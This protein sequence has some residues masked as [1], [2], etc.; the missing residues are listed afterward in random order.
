V[1]PRADWYVLDVRRQAPYAGVEPVLLEDDGET[2][3]VARNSS[4]SDG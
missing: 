3:C 2:L 1:A 4:P